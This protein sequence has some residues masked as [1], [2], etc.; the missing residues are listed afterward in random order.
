MTLKN[1][2]MEVVDSISVAGVSSV[3][4]FNDDVSV[5]VFFK[6]KNKL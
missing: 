5:A 1:I 3:V 2:P 6:K 4:V